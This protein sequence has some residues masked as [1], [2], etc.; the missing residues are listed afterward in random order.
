MRFEIFEAYPPDRDG[1]VAELHFPSGRG[2]G[3]PIHVFREQG[4]VKVVIFAPEGGVAWEFRL[5]ELLDGLQ[6]AAE[7]FGG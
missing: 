3:V 6:R 1:A 2:I 7:V 4:E 5:A